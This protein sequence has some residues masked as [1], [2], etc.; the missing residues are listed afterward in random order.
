MLFTKR[1]RAHQR[2]AFRLR[3]VQSF[4][5]FHW[6]RNRPR[7][8]RHPGAVWWRL[9]DLPPSA[10]AEPHAPVFLGLSSDGLTERGGTKGPRE[11]SPFAFS[12]GA[13]LRRSHDPLARG[14]RLS[15]SRCD[16]QIALEP[17]GKALRWTSSR[18]TIRC[19]QMH[20]APLSAT[21]ARSSSAPRRPWVR[22]AHVRL[23]QS[24]AAMVAL[25]A[26]A[27]PAPAGSAAC[28]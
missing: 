26:P 23:L 28:C 6:Q 7:F 24:T 27:W 14:S 21:C 11:R 2:R 17:L 15:S 1:R 16:D 5:L 25:A 12:I 22:A 8:D 18:T 13:M 19:W 9:H 4:I 3:A 10:L 20:R